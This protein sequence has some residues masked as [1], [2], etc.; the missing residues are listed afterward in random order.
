MG[1]FNPGLWEAGVYVFERYADKISKWQLVAHTGKP[2]PKLEGVIKA[3]TK[4][5]NAWD[6][7]EAHFTQAELTDYYVADKLN[8]FKR[9]S[10][11]SDISDI[12]A[13]TWHIRLFGLDTLTGPLKSLIDNFVQ[14]GGTAHPR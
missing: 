9:S 4:H 7:P 14:H 5:F 2:Q 8:S 1:L 10:Y 6:N 3:V 11:R 12:E 13:R